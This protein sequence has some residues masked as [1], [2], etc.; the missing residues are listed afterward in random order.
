MRRTI[1]LAAVLLVGGSG[2]WAADLTKIDRTI[3][4]QPVYQSKSPRYGLLVFGPAAQTR[5][6]V[7]V[8]GNTLLVD[9]KGKGDLSE[10]KRVKLSDFG[11]WFKAGGI[12][13]AVKDL[14]YTSG[15]D[16][17]YN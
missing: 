14:R 12:Q 11:S 3:R 2:S 5:A 7:V 15:G 13:V 16:W 17:F 1:C 8:D 9:E 4:H 10:A 6:W